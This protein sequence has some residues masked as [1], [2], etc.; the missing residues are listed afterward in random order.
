MQ[1]PNRKDNA[2]QYPPN[3]TLLSL[4]YLLQRNTLH[5]VYFILGYDM[6]SLGKYEISQYS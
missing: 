2:P 1:N 6:T 5:N 3:P 4:S